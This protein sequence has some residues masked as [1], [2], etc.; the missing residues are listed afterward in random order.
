M[1]KYIIERM[2]SL[3]IVLVGITIITFLLG[4]IT[5]GDPAELSLSRGGN[6]S[7]TSEQIEQRREEM[8]LNKPVY[9]Q[10]LDWIKGV[11][12]GDFGESYSS[13]ESVSEMIRRKLPITVKLALYSIGI[14]SFLGISLGIISAIYKDTLIDGSINLMNNIMLSLPNFWLALLFI[15]FFSEILGWLPTSGNGGWKHMLM[16]AFSLS[17]VTIATTARVMRSSMIQEFGKQYYLALKSKGISKFNLYIRNILPNS[18]LPILTLLANF[19]GSILG[20]SAV[21][22]TIFAL[23]GIG[24]YAIESIYLK[25]FPYLQAYVLITGFVFVLVT[26]LIDI[27][28][29]IIDPKIRIG[30]DSYEN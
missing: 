8:G 17:L 9:I 28:S 11:L 12:K 16:P 22:E 30:A 7:P 27:V 25:D 21:I 29:I 2:K 20:G 3:F 1:K 18:I 24:S 15:L 13:N 4:L 23:P 10:Y 5:P 19:M 14:T 26:T 6:Y